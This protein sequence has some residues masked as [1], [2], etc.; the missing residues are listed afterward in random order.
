MSRNTRSHIPFKGPSR[1][2][3]NPS[4]LYSQD[5]TAREVTENLPLSQIQ[6]G[7]Q[8]VLDTVKFTKGLNPL[9][10][11]NPMELRRKLEKSLLE[12]SQA[13]DEFCFAFNSYID[14][15]DHLK[16]CLLPFES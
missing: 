15:P 7:F 2:V 8:E 1:K 10:V 9:V 6:S 14:N 3:A 11:N 16:K 4:H 5:M 12:K 13:T